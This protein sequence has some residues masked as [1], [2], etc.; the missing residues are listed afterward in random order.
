MATLESLKR[1][2]RQ[3]VTETAASSPKQSLSDAQYSAGLDIL[4]WDAEWKTYPDFIIPQLSQVLASLFKWHRNI[5]ALEIG[6]G[7]Q[8]LLAC[9]PGHLRRKIRSYTAF[10]P[11]DLFATRLEEWLCSKSG[12]WSSLPCLESPPIIHRTPF[13]LE[14]EVGSVTATRSEDNKYDIILFRHRMYGTKSKRKLVERALRMLVKEPKGGMVV[15]FDHDGVLHLDG[16]GVSSDGF[17][18]RSRSRGR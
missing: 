2:L 16:L 3:K 15:V 18:L 6:P 5:S 14:D 11:N 9:L 12:M 4:A 10:E 17:F 8:S 7:P 1:A 13:V